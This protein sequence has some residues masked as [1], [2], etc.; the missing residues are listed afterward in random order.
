MSMA[1]RTFTKWEILKILG[2]AVR[3]RRR[4]LGKNQQEIASACGMAATYISDIEHGHK[5]LDFLKIIQI[6]EALEESP[7][8]FFSRFVELTVNAG[9]GK[10]DNE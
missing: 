6:A 9:D 7:D 1:K 3:E 2:K 4:E 8:Q 5:N 10:C